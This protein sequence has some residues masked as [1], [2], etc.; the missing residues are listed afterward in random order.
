M[1]IHFTPSPFDLSVHRAW[2]VFQSFREPNPRSDVFSSANCFVG[3][4]T[5]LC[6]TRMPIRANR[7]VTH[8]P[9][10]MAPSTKLSEL[11]QSRQGGGGGGRRLRF[12]EGLKLKVTRVGGQEV[13]VTARRQTLGWKTQP[14]PHAPWNQPHQRQTGSHREVAHPGS[15][16]LHPTNLNL[17]PNLAGTPAQRPDLFS[18][19]LSTAN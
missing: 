5:K 12:E 18:T 15:N 3:F 7:T 8:T 10:E 2:I 1:E 6:D 13:K 4:L 16:S 14:N 17:H 19:N 11:R 9:R